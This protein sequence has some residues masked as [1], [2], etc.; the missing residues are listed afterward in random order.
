[1]I[2]FGASGHGKV[3]YDIINDEGCYT[4]DKF[5]DDNPSGS[6]FC[7]L[8]LE[9]SNNTYYEEPAIIAIGNNMTRAKVSSRFKKFITAI[10]PSSQISKYCSIKEGT[11]IMPGVVINHSCK[12][13]KH[14]I[15]N[16]NCSV[17]HDCII[18]DF[19]H[20]SPNVGLAGNIHIGKYTHVGI[21]A[22]IIQGI[23][24]GKNVTIGA[25]SVIIEDIPNNAVVVGNPGKIIKYQ[26]Y[27]N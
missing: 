19:V 21:G 12:I 9:K 5:I 16:T 8:P 3:I 15:L 13:G 24:I 26:T 22:N 18:E 14:C 6:S 23:K 2:I 17:D 25:G 11:V 10:H 20:I 7:N 4:I 27:E 1:M